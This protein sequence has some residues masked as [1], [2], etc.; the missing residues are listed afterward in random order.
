M[1]GG[2][3]IGAGASVSPLTSPNSYTIKSPYKYMT[4]S[5]TSS[6]SLSRSR[7]RS[8]SKSHNHHHS[9]SPRSPFLQTITSCK[10]SETSAN[11]SI[12]EERPTLPPLGLQ[13][14]GNTCYANAA[15]QCLLNTALSHALLDP[16]STQIFRRYSSNPDLLS[17]GSGSVDSDEEED[18]EDEVERVRRRETRRRNREARRRT[19]EKLL[20][21]EKCQWLTGALTDITRIY[22]AG[23][24]SNQFPESDSKSTW[25]SLLHLFSVSNNNRIVDPSGVTRHVHKLSPCLRPYQQEDAHEFIRTLLSTLTLDGRNKQLSSLFD[26]L[27]ES[28]VTCQTCH[29]ASVTR[30]RYMD[31]SLDIQNHDVNDL[32]GALKKFTMTEM[33]DEDNKV[34]CSRCNC[35][36]V[37]SK[38]LRLATAPSI[39]VCHLKRFAFDMFG[40]ATRLSKRVKYPLVLEIGDFMSRANQGRPAPYELVGVVVHAGKSCERGHYLAYVKSGNDWYKANDEVVTKVNVDIV[41]NQQAYILIYEIE[42]MRACHGLYGCGRYHFTRSRSSKKRAED[43]AVMNSPSDTSVAYTASLSTSGEEQAKSTSTTSNGRLLTLLDSMIDMCGS[44]TAEA[45]RDAMCDTNNNKKPNEEK[46]KQEK[47]IHQKQQ[48]QQQRQTKETYL[49]QAG[50]LQSTPSEESNF[51][52]VTPSDDGSSKTTQP[53]DFQRSRSRRSSSVDR[54]R[55]S[56]ENN[57][58]F[59]N[60]VESEPSSDKLDIFRISSSLPDASSGGIE[61]TIH[62]QKE[63][64]SLTADSQLIKSCSSNNLLEREEEVAHGYERESY[65]SCALNYPN[66]MTVSLHT[67][68]TIKLPRQEV[69]QKSDPGVKAVIRRRK[70]SSAPRA[71]RISPVRDKYDKR[72][73][74]PPLPLPMAKRSSS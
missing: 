65:P 64:V 42:G 71:I 6:R 48:Q 49:K 8:R 43:L 50:P 46:R 7:S 29:R 30:D 72:L 4:P 21:Q 39:L 74:L 14:V 10:T 67:T 17:V 18:T 35:K 1:G 31:L 66:S 38:G 53:A 36:Q 2:S 13:N 56:S 22:T 11:N 47:Q 20:S 16:A 55:S 51:S 33:L 19:R 28:A 9:H 25:Q 59:Y 37:V 32:V 63:Q 60:V 41:L 68:N 40:R 70:S 57:A 15:L 69:D 27:L 26:G 73:D 58:L 44:T 54:I 62:S 3:G 12:H 23:S 61:D 34:H 5:P 52:R 24:N 45:V